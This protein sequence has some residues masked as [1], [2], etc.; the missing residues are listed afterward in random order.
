M[1]IVPCPSGCS[2]SILLLLC[3][4]GCVSGRSNAQAVPIASTVSNPARGDVA[5]VR[6]PSIIRE[7]KTYYVFSTDPALHAPGQYLP[8]RCSEDRVTWRLC[9]HVFTAMPPWVQQAVPQANNLWAPDISFFNGL[10]HLYYSAS[11]PGSQLSGIGL[12]TNTTL[13]ATSP[14]YRW[15]GHGLVLG[16]HPGDDFNAIDPN[17]FV[18]AGHRVWLTYGSSWTGIKQ[19]EIDPAT[20]LLLAPREAAASLAF[21]PDHRVVE[22]PSLVFH[23]GFYY[24]FVSYGR[25]CDPDLSRDDYREAVGRSSS[26]H[27]PFADREGQPLT[28]GGGTVLL[29]GNATW[30]APGGATAWLDPQNGDAFLVFHALDVEHHGRA[31]LWMKSIAWRDGWPVLD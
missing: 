6:D 20:G 11:T 21:R 29:Q 17:L 22:G 18:D 30:V 27:G 28:R 26:L 12:A 16:S 24:L 10:Y 3:L 4:A 8:I 2:R 25:C 9:G 31:N 19:R 5:P 23:Q 7:G 14:A 1:R 15:V 13:D